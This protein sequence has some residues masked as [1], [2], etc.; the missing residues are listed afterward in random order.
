V[1]TS[2]GYE[3][4]QA[5]QLL[6]VVKEHWPG[7]ARLA[8]LLSLA[9][10]A[11]PA[12]LRAARLAAGLDAAAEADLWFSG[13]VA[14]R[15]AL[16]ISLVPTVAEVL[17][18]E[19]ARSPA[20]RDLAWQLIE[21]HHGKDPW[22]I[23]LEER[24]NYLTTGGPADAAEVDALLRAAL[25][26]LHEVR[27]HNERAAVG[28]A[29]W[30]LAA[31]ARAPSAAR[32]TSLAATAQVAAGVHLDGRLA[33]PGDLAD[34]ESSEL[35]PWLLD[36]LG[37]TTIPVQL[38]PGAVAIGGTPA[39]GI[40]LPV[41]RTDPLVISVSWDAD[42]AAQ[43]ADVRVPAGEETLVPV[44]GT[45][46]ELRTI[47]GG[48]LLLR[49]A[50]I[51]RILVGG[52]D[53]GAGFAV[54]G[55]AV[56]TAAHNVPDDGA[57]H[58]RTSGASA[59]AYLTEAGEAVPAEVSATDAD[60]D[61]ALLRL[62]QPVP[63]VLPVGDYEVGAACRLQ[64]RLGTGRQA[65]GGTVTGLSSASPGFLESAADASVRLEISGNFG[66]LRGHSGAPA[67]LESPWGAVI[68]MLVSEQPVS[69]G[70]QRLQAVPIDAMVARFGLAGQVTY[71]SPGL[72]DGDWSRAAPLGELLRQVA[73]GDIMPRLRDVGP[74]M[75]DL[76]IPPEDSVLAGISGLDALRRALR[77]ADFIVVSGPPIVAPV[78][79]EEARSIFPDARLVLPSGIE[80]LRALAVHPAILNASE[81]IVVWLDDIWSYAD[82]TAGFL[83]SVLPRL[84]GRGQPTT[85][86]AT[87]SATTL[88]FSRATQA[89]ASALWA[90][91]T[92]VNLGEPP[93]PPAASEA[94]R[95]EPGA[96]PEPEAEAESAAG[97]APDDAAARQLAESARL[98][99][100]GQYEEA[101]QAAEAAVT[102]YQELA[103][104]VRRYAPS[105]AG[106]LAVLSIRFADV[107]R[108][109]DA[110]AAIQEAV[111]IYR[112]LEA[113]EPRRY[114]AE[115]A[116][117][118]GAL[119]DR[120]GTMGRWQ[121][122]LAV[123]QEPVDI[124]RQLGDRS[125]EGTALNNLGVAMHAVGQLADAV[126][127]FQ[128][129]LE[130]YQDTGDR[131]GQARALHNLGTALQEMGQLEDATKALQGAVQIYRGT[132]DLRG[133]GA[134]LD[135]LGGVLQE[136]RRFEEAIAAYQDAATACRTA[137]YA[138]GEAR[139]TGDLGLAFEGAGRLDEAIS[140]H[141]AA[142]DLFRRSGEPRGE[143]KV[144][145]N[146]G[147][148]LQRAGR[149]PDAVQAYQAALDLYRQVGD[150][151]GRETVQR[152]L[153]A[154]QGSAEA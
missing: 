145:D 37:S 46:V 109:A 60:L 138:H 34:A 67:T 50:G 82:D 121:D 48:R 45:Q 3:S 70:P 85:V 143:A 1:T 99:E 120:L 29:R 115:L 40:P 91:A 77:S 86:I 25:T 83:G 107:G 108:A 144:R 137:G 18:G 88:P 22:S 128:G 124:Y 41:P 149:F 63:D 53:R 84:T 51:G 36:H 6:A 62:A 71:A 141:Y 132:G 66:D 139:A 49:R 7:A 79:Y 114:L 23:R 10:R 95:V 150:Q 89:D 142:A 122:A 117:A 113:R 154:L 31:L 43:R 106:A 140:A 131:P 16:G 100:A 12:L 80:S 151:A 39:D 57:A 126:T 102:A 116:A 148:A 93:A 8:R 136:Q 73:E 64:L 133:E 24:V 110:L 38:L 9:V 69:S 58:S 55:Q 123:A 44:T 118:L 134:V 13:I 101:V 19:L 5:T 103:A 74:G 61:A 94:M 54:A 125:G 98:A 30:L 146:L 153:D 27:Q 35:L 52:R 32:A 147:T 59:I 47:T 78:T 26:E 111:E 65:P 2:S 42:G 81:R 17:R 127:S 130:S 76:G 92:L 104:N 28:I 112:Q 97:P 96:E 72:V 11:E 56:L 129:A 119:G 152:H 90:R 105:L 15:S 21:D 87:T 68:G 75:L 20:D 33:D 135:S 4:A 14:S